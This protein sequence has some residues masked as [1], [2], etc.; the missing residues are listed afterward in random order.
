MNPMGISIYNNRHR[1]RGP[2]ICRIS[3][4]STENLEENMSLTEMT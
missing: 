4:Q 1:Q 3:Y 2:N